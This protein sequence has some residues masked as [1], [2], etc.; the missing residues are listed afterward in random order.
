MSSLRRMLLPLLVVL[1]LGTSGCVAAALVGAAG[2]GAGVGYSQSKKNQTPTNQR[3]TKTEATARPAPTAPRSSG[4][5]S[6]RLAPAPAALVECKLQD[7]ET[8]A[9]SAADCKAKGGSVS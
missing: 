4:S 7:G 8:F 6:V 3:S 1:L 9:M 5:S 2:A